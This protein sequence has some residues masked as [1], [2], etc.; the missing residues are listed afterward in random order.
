MRAA[1][2]ASDHVYYRRDTRLPILPPGLSSLVASPACTNTYTVPIA[3]PI[4]S[5]IILRTPSIGVRR[6]PVLAKVRLPPRLMTAFKGSLRV[7]VC[8][9]VRGVCK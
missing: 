9:N 8:G 6:H 2:W 1:A 5:L 3:V 7:L 4:M